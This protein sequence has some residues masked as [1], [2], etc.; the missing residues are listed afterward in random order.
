MDALYQGALFLAGGDLGGAE[1]LL[2]DTVTLAFK[3]HPSEDLEDTQRWFEARLVRSF[4]RYVKDGPLQLPTSTLDRVA[5]DPA[6]FDSM[7]ADE[8]FV[9]AAKIPP[10]PR[11]AL[12]LILLRRWSY[13]DSAS[14]LNLELS[15]LEVLL[16][17]RDVLM[18]EALGHARGGMVMG[19]S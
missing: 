2:V 12:W 16:A 8:L 13:E 15:E 1:H 11:A 17:Y 14:V 3:E 7:G 19:M 18:Q 9:A 5:L 4:L 6:T 10:W